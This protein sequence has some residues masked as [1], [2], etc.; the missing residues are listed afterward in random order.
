MNEIDRAA[1]LIGGADGLLL[2]AGAGIGVDS[3]LPDFRG[4]SGFWRAYPALA[5]ARIAFEEIANPAA[6]A[7]DPRLAW[8]FYGHRLELYRRTVPHR[9]YEILL[10]IAQRLAHGCFVFTSNVDGQFVR[11]GFASDAVCECHG[12]IH[13]L[14]CARACADVVWSADSFVPQVDA[15]A[16]RL[17]S[18]LPGCSGCGGLARPNILMFGDGDWIEMPMRRQ[19][20]RLDGWLSRVDRLLVIEIG[21]GM[22][23]PTVRWF[24]EMRGEPLIRINPREAENPSARGVS[25]RMGGLAALQAIEA[26][27]IAEG[28]L[29]GPTDL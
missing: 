10:R 5:A 23:V 22:Q 29:A 28:F 25:I 13:F 27:L 12:S 8:G 21:A 7:R 24:G 16:C 19:Q 18:P 4:T 14:Q 9:G 20:R 15:A 11:A 1:A 6:F 2:T 3:G 26:A 17:V